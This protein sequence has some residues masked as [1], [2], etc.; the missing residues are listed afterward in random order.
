MPLTP[1]FRVALVALLAF[2]FVSVIV[3]CHWLVIIIVSYI[4]LFSKPARKQTTELY[5]VLHAQQDCAMLKCVRAFKINMKM[6]NGL[7]IQRK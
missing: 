1:A 6:T 2:P 7:Q 4:S 3:C 5:I